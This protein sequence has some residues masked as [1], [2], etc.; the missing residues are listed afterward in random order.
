M[1]FTVVFHSKLGVD[2]SYGLV[3]IPCPVWVRGGRKIINLN[4]ASPHYQKGS[5]QRLLDREPLEAALAE[6]H[7]KC[8]LVVH[9]DGHGT[10]DDIETL[11]AD[12]LDVGFGAE[13]IH[14]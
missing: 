3:F 6:G 9:A 14:F 11:K 5:V 10:E 2:L 1:E 12:L 7:R 8:L 4:P 13:V